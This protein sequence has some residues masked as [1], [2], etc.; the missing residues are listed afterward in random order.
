MS[1]RVKTEG[2][3]IR[4]GWLTPMAV[5]VLGLT[6]RLYGITNPLV[7]SHQLRQCQTATMTRNLFVDNMDI[8]HT[9]L[10][11]FG[12]TPGHII[13]E[14]PLFNGITA[15]LY[16]IFGIHE[17]I[18]RMVNV[19]FSVGAM[20][21]IY[22]LARHFLSVSGAFAALGLY[23]LSPMNIYFSRTFMPESSMMFFLVAAVYLSLKW[24]EK[25]TIFLYIG[26]AIC[27]MLACLIKP[28]A[29]VIIAPILSAWFLKHKWKLLQDYHFW[30][31]LFFA[32]IPLA[33]W[34]LYANYF[35]MNS[36]DIP[37]GFGGVWLDVI[38]KRGGIFKYWIDP[39]FYRNMGG[40]IILLLLTP[41]GFIGLIAGLIVTP[42]SHNRTILYIWL[43]SVIVYFYALS[44]ANSGHVYYQ[45]PLLP[46]AVIFFGSGVE[47]LLSKWDFLKKIS[48]RKWFFMLGTI[49][50][51]VFLFGYSVGYFRFFSYMYD[52]K[53]RMPYV[54]EVSNIIKEGTPK[55]RVI[56][57]YQ[58]GAVPGT[59]TYYSQ[60]KTWAFHI[61]TDEQAIEDLEHFRK[62]GA[63]TYVA[64]D[65]KYGSGV[66]GTRRH[67]I[68]WDYLTENYMPIAMTDNYLVFDIRNPKK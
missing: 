65:T 32:V 39:V 61:Y 53:L 35:N 54:L 12:N 63:T 3:W 47:W 30:I 38:T 20:F 51:L 48:K 15:L 19:G 2:R 33:L 21:L 56:L 11:F 40:S 60:C 18:G 29:A 64:H 59:L 8:F 58:P 45:L 50:V 36:P 68:F 5:V 4:C 46:V 10:D 31:F 13:M 28:P 66:K 25:D 62:R 14:F 34:G 26:A 6:L 22:G 42:K 49:V 37:D 16:Y 52:T 24:L 27:T 41:L 9:R 1:K 23:A 44:A 43:G 67:K 17:I 7:D 57:L 55:N